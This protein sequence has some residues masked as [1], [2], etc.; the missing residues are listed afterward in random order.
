[1]NKRNAIKL[2]MLL[3]LAGGI[4]ALYFTP[5]RAY[6]T[7]AHINDFIAW[8]RGLWYGPI[9]LIALYA[10]GCVFALP[11]S[12][13]VIAAGVIWGWKLGGLY[14]IIGGFLGAIAAYYVGGFLGEGLLDKFGSVGR[15]V[16]KQVESSGF[17]SML[18]VRL[19]PGPPFAVWN[20]AAGV[21][22]M[23]FRDYALATLI[24]IIPS[25]LVFTYCADSLVNGTMT[26]G[27]ALK[28]LA[29]VC[30]LLLALILIPLFIKKRMGVKTI[31]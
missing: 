29:I 15:G 9:V 2:A 25:H 24:G 3:V 26:Q 5:L 11:A 7:K 14:S 1:M 20:Y 10:A 17:L 13:F 6:L 21:A 4:A 23:R 12:I 30:A 18:I 19:I 8:L 22:K 16:R 31:E 27:D 28:R